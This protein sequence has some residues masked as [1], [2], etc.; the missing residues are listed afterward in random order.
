M[1][2]NYQQRKKIYKHQCKGNFRTE[3]YNNQ[4]KNLV[5][6]LSRMEV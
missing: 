4:N 6:S 1:N 2:R 3:K 5:D